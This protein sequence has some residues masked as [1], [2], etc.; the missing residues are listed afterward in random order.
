MQSDTSMLYKLM[1]L[2]ML[3]R[4]NFPL[5]NA[6]LTDF[7]LEKEYTNYFNLQRIIS[8]LLDD[9]YIQGTTI[10]NSTLYKISDSGRETLRLFQNNISSGIKEDIDAY[11]KDNKYELHN[12]VSSPAYYYQLKNDEF[13]AHLSVK[14]MDTTLIDL[15]L[16]VPTEEE[17]SRLCSN[18][19]AKS[20]EV[21]SYLM[22][23]LLDQNNDSYGAQSD[24]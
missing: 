6:Q 22:S 9:E 15:T 18:W 14:E 5:T 1:L 4:V 16:T 8:E 17:A 23:V 10:R 11:L 19:R 20:S 2:Y 13:A 24:D 12:E 21:Y 3:S 7:M